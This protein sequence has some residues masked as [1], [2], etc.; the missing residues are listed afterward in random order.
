M[1]FKIARH[2]LGCQN[3]KFKLVP[4]LLVMRELSNNMLKDPHLAAKTYKKCG[5]HQNALFF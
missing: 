1:W 2:R 5:P 4:F 3:F